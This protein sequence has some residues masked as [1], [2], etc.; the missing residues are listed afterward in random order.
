MTMYSANGN[1]FKIFFD[2]VN[3]AKAQSCEVIQI[4]N[5]LVRWTPPA[6]ISA[7]RMRQYQ[8]QLNAYKASQSK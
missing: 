1:E 2:A 5:G 8:N 4:D 6:P 7:K 3:Y